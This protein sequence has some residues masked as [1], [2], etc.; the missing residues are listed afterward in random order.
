MKFPSG[1]VLV[2]KDIDKVFS[3]C[4][5]FSNFIKESASYG[6]EDYELELD[7]DINDPVRV[8][9]HITVYA[10]ARYENGRDWIMDLKILKI[11]KNNY[12]TYR[13]ERIAVYV[14]SEY[15]NVKPLPLSFVW[16]NLEFGI[17][18]YDVK[19]ATRIDFINYIKPSSGMLFKLLARVLHLLGFFKHNELLKKWAGTVE[20]NA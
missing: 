3:Y 5:S 18:F 20:K 17:I 7:E 9:D 1:S 14:D 12:I 19:G 4:C 15:R 11:S 2:H 10:Y 13:I 6:L 16:E 8:G